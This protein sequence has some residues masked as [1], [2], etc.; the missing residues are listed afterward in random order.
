MPEVALPWLTG[1]MLA[2]VIQREGAAAS[3]LDGWRWRELK[4]LPVA[5]YDV[6]ARILTKVGDTGVWPVGLL[7]AYIAMIP[8]LMVMPL[9]LAKGLSVLTAGSSLGFLTRFSA[10]VVVVGRLRLGMPLLLILRRFLLVL[11]ILMFISLLLMLSS[12]LMLLTG[13]FGKGFELS[14]FA[15]LVS[16]CSF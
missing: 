12:L 9:L 4:V 14:G 7:D 16:S 5:W 2:D 11:P 15:C 10:L 3:S 1:Q 6:L 8:R 13:D